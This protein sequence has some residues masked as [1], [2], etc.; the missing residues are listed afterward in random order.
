[1]SEFLPTQEA[2]SPDSVIQQ[3]IERHVEGLIVG[4]LRFTV[5]HDQL[6]VYA[7]QQEIFEFEGYLET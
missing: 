2:N 4:D 6:S 5:F 1:M 7:T 3:E